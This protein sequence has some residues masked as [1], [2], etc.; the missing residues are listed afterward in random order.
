[1][2]LYPAS[3][4]YNARQYNIIQYRTTRYNTVTHIT[5]NNTQHARQRS[6]LKIANNQEHVLFSIKTHKQ[7]EPKVDGSVLKTTTC[8][9]QSVN[10]TTLHYTTLHS[11]TLRTFHQNLHPTPPHHPYVHFISHPALIT[12]PSPH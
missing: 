11:T 5:Q 1:M 8:T 4:R 9:E 3:M 12:S 6:V 10:H 2:V 7:L